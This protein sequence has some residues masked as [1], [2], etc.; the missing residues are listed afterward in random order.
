MFFLMLNILAVLY[1]MS[2]CL[3]G[4][5][6]SRIFEEASLWNSRAFVSRRYSLEFVRIA[7][8]DNTSGLSRAWQIIQVGTLTENVHE[9][10]KT[11]QQLLTHVIF[12]R[13]VACSC[14][15]VGEIRGLCPPGE[16]PRLP[17]TRSESGSRH[18]AD[19]RTRGEGGVGTF[20]HSE[21]HASRSDL[22]PHG[23]YHPSFEIDAKNLA[24]RSVA[25]HPAPSAIGPS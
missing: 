18:R 25:D 23:T 19:V 7:F 2:C 3:S 14:I 6:S 21:S 17:R 13:R 11:I 16:A 9:G 1:W 15:V 12:R 22:L 8:C 5:G 20:R 24:A 10:G 4:F